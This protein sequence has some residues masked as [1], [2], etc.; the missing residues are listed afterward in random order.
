M[1]GD[2]PRGAD[3]PVANASTIGA[4]GDGAVGVEERGGDEPYRLVSIDAVCAPEG[5][6]G[7]DWHIYRIMQGE[8]GIT[9]HRRGDLARVRSD[10]E[11]IVTALNK[12]RQWTKHE[13]PSKSQRR[14][15]AAARRA[16]A[17]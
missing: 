10:V 16:A 8:N 1:A 11:A 9:G 6:I 15:A 7:S 5:C 12:R 17:T 3:R 2:K 13:V 14:A 4:R